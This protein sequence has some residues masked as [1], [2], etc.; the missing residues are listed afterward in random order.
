[1][2]ARFGYSFNDV[3]NHLVLIE[4]EGIK[5]RSAGSG[6]VAFMDGKRNNFV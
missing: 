4:C 1:M 5:G 3:Q 6:F 2:K